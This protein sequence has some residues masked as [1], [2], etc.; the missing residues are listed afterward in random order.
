MHWENNMEPL[1][2]VIVP[3]YKVEDYL[4][5]C[6]KSIVNQTYSNIEIILVD[7]GSP[8]KCPQMC[9]EWAAKD[10]RIIV[11]H[12]HNAGVSSARNEGLK[13]AT[14]EW[15][16]FVDSDDSV[17]EEAL[18]EIVSKSDSDIDLIIFNCNIDS[19]YIKD[20]KFFDEHY[21]KYHFGFEAWNKLYNKAIVDNNNLRFD[22][23]ETIGED[24]L[25]NITYYQFA[26]KYLF[27][28]KKY[29]NYNIR[30]T[31][32]MH[33]NTSKRLDQQLSLYSKIY[34]IYRNKLDERTLAQLFIM[35]LISGINQCGK[36]NI[37]DKAG[38]IEDSIKKYNFSK[39]AFKKAISCFLDCEN[40]S[41]LGRIRAT[42][43]LRLINH[44]NVK[45]ALKLM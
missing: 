32:A 4:D 10:E 16:W 35:H 29:Y 42:L 1:V 27:I 24:L 5:E 15:I 38:L 9:D 2:S 36:Q 37:G 13:V 33:S 14:G 8:D 34:E 39:Q 6:V 26:E 28:S 12:K 25:F 3:V 45:S 30:E 17:C 18:E 23:E 19:L 20:E 44:G 22:T 41:A 40:A 11:I 7:D 31:S 21:F 43:V